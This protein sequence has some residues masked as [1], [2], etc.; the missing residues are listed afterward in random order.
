[1]DLSDF[2]A[3]DMDDTNDQP[4]SSVTTIPRHQFAGSSLL[5]GNG[6]SNVITVDVQPSTLGKRDLRSLDDD[7]EEINENEDNKV[8]CCV[9]F[10]N[11]P[12]FSSLGS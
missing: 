2:D 1:M 10:G 3:F 4:I 7:G 11:I 9:L 8:R 6:T 12:L 5:S